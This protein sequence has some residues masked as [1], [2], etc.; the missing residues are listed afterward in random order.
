MPRIS[1]RFSKKIKRKGHA[2]HVYSKGTMWYIEVDE[3]YKKDNVSLMAIIAHEMA[4]VVLLRRHVELHPRQRNEELTDT[5][6]ILGGFGKAISVSHIKTKIMNPLGSFLLLFLGVLSIKRA[7]TRL[8]Y[9][10]NY[11]IEHLCKIKNL[12][13]LGPPIKILRPIYTSVSRLVDCYSCSQKLRIPDEIA[14]REGEFYLTCPI[15]RMEHCV[16][17][18]RK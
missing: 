9:L 2:A 15:C 1:V 10:S 14:D 12:I 8:G 13:S 16:V 6:S 3:C 4:H 18:K 11:E 7:T 17:L 5:V